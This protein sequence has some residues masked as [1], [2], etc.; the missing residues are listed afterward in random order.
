MLQ[1]AKVDLVG[2]RFKLFFFVSDN[3]VPGYVPPS[4]A[5]LEEGCSKYG[6]HSI[7]QYCHIVL[8]NIPYTTSS[9]MPWSVTLISS[10]SGHEDLGG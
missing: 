8:K 4:A 3:S 9:C 10:D 6:I 1:S 2:S 7:L 5:L